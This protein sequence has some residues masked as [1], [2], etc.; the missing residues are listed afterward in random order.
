MLALEGAE[1]W[2]RYIDG[3]VRKV[4]ALWRLGKARADVS[5]GQRQPAS[6]VEQLP[7]QGR[8]PE[9]RVRLG[10]QSGDAGDVGGG[11]A[12]SLQP[13]VE[14][15]PRETGVNIDPRTRDVHRCVR[16]VEPSV[17]EGSWP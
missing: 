1:A 13:A 12:R 16:E 2:E 5:T 10:P 9:H 3:R 11:H 4:E 15:R 6:A 8:A 14:Y 17:G 7:A